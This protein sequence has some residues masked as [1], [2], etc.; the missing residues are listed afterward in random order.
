[1][2]EHQIFK[3]G[4]N[5]ITWDAPAS[6]QLLNLGDAHGSSTSTTP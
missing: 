4:K 3:I 1:M 2:K 6:P 5:H